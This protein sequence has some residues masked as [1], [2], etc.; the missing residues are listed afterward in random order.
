MTPSTAL[1]LTAIY[2]IPA[3]EVLAALIGGGR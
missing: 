2:A 1:I 3:A